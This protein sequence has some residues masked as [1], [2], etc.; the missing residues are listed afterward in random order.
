MEN[1]LNQ[2]RYHGPLEGAEQLVGVVH[3]ETDAV[4]VVH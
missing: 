2:Q 4:F 3:V 1:T